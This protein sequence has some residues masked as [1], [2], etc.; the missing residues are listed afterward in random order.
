M[1]RC[2]ISENLV[3]FTAHVATPL[4]ASEIAAT[5]TPVIIN[6]NLSPMSLLAVS[7][8]GIRITHESKRSESTSI[9]GEDVFHQRITILQIYLA[10]HHK[11]I[12][13][14]P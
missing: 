14:L 11:N 1:P 10:H 4:F 6:S 3:I 2:Q 8:S 9:L 12:M 13:Q 5:A 7:P